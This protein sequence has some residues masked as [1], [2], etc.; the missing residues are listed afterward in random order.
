MNK[1]KRNKIINVMLDI[2]NMLLTYG[3]IKNLF[4]RKRR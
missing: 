4:K 1:N 2:V 3:L